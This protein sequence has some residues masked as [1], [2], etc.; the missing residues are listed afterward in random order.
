MCQLDQRLGSV[1]HQV[2]HLGAKRRQAVVGTGVPGIKAAIRGHFF[3]QQI[4]CSQVHAHQHHALEERLIHG[5][6]ARS[7]L[8]LGNA[9]LLPS[10][11]GFQE[12]AL[13]R[14]HDTSQGAG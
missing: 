14:V 3:H 4:A 9:F 11:C 12:E 7:Y 10:G 5:P 2:Q 6:D 13:Q 8:A 1:T